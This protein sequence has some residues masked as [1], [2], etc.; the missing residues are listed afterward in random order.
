V[1]TFVGV[2]EKTASLTARIVLCSAIVDA[3]PIAPAL[4]IT[5]PDSARAN[6][7][8]SLLRRLCWHSIPL[9]SVTPTSFC[10]LASGVRYTYVISQANVSNKLQ[11]LLDDASRRD[12]KIPSRGGL[13]NLFGVQVIQ[14]DSVLVDDSSPLRSIQISVTPSETA[15]PAFDQD[16]QQ[17]IATEFQAKL[18]S[19]RRANLGA[20][21]R[22]TSMH[23]SLV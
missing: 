3:L 20:A 12:Q 23:R 1:T 14:G 17:R 13:L 16:A 21:R 7:L 6:R 9:T 4:L 18:L 15:L 22:L 11:K 2:D 19:F 10:S 5:G 8:V